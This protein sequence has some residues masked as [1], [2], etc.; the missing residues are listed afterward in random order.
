MNGCA[1][2]QKKSSATKIGKHIPC[3]YSMLKI[4]TFNHLENK[5]TLYRGEN[6]I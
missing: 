2:N 6:Y 1:K 5:Y 3:G 4:L